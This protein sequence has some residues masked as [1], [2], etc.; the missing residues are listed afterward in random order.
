MPPKVEGEKEPWQLEAEALRAEL[1][2]LAGQ[3]PN[4]ETAPEV[5]ALREQLKEALAQLK[6]LAE[7]KPEDNPQATAK[8]TAL[9]TRL[10]ELVAQLTE[11]QKSLPPKKD[12]TPQAPDV[13]PEAKQ[14]RNWL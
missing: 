4:L 6:T 1:A 5:K 8:L 14:K 2:K 12:G 9:E 7:K 13:L 11:I 3:L 10:G